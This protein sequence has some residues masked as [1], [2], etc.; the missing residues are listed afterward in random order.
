M[1]GSSESEAQTKAS[2]SPKCRRSK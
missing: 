2:V 1:K